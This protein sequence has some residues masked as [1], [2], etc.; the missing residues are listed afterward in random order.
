MWG[1]NSKK[2][3]VKYRRKEENFRINGRNT[4]GVY[5]CVAK[6]SI[7][8][9]GMFITALQNDRFL[10]RGLSCDSNSQNSGQTKHKLCPKCSDHLAAGWVG[11]AL[12]LPQKIFFQEP[13]TLT[14]TWMRSMLRAY[15]DLIWK[16]FPKFRSLMA[17]QALPLG[18]PEALARVQLLVDLERPLLSLQTA[19]ADMTHSVWVCH[20][21]HGLVVCTYVSWPAPAL[22]S[23]VM[24]VLMVLCTI[25]GSECGRDRPGFGFHSVYSKLCAIKYFRVQIEP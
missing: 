21:F 1:N 12:G 9:A 17:V 13:V 3:R 18:L 8:L 15:W 4:N 24:L 14:P 20:R 19:D 5:N 11:P 2:I 10:W 6:W 25:D 16:F 7:S 22:C 23:L